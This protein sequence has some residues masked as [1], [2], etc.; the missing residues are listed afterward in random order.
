MQLIKCE[1]G[2]TILRSCRQRTKK[3]FFICDDEMF[4][5][6]FQAIFTLIYILMVCVLIYILI[7]TFN[8]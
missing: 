5:D 8:I 3:Y 2:L 6:N 1:R 4:R 7:Y